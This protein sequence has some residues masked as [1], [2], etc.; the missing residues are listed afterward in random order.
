MS[1]YRLYCGRSINDG[2]YVTNQD[3]SLFEKILN[4]DY[5][6]DFT[7]IYAQGSWQRQVED[8]V[9]YDIEGPLSDIKLASDRYKELFKQEKIGL[10]RVQDISFI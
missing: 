7:R 3:L 6:L 5:Q 2:G 1:T 8:V 4:N 9:L 10:S